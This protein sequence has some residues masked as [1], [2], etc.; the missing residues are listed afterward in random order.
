MSTTTAGTSE[1]TASTPMAVDS[2]PS[3]ASPPAKKQKTAAAAASGERTGEK[4][5]YRVQKRGTAALP[6]K[7]FYRQRAH[8]NPFSDHNLE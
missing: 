2:T 7:K 8:A 6:K 4:A 3:A 5:Q 1:P